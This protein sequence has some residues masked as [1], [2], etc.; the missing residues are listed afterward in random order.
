MEEIPQ[1]KG[2]S[3]LSYDAEKIPQSKGGG[4]LL[5]NGEVMALICSY[6]KPSSPKDNSLMEE[7]NQS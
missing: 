4:V 3:V 2:G 6:K 1:S 5:H 7:I